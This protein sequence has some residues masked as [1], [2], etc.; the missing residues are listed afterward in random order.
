MKHT[1]KTFASPY[2][3]LG[4]VRSLAMLPGITPIIGPRFLHPHPEVRVLPSPGITRLLQYYDP[5]PVPV[6]P[7][8][9]PRAL[10]VVSTRAGVPPIAQ[11]TLPACRAHYPGGPEA[12]RVSVASRLGA[13]FPVS[14]AGRR[15][16]LHFRGL[17]R[18]HSRY[19][20]QGCSAT[21][22]GPA[23]ADH[24]TPARPVTGPSRLSATR[25]TD[26]YLGGTFTHR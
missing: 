4:N 19:R 21:V 25:L 10:K 11:T 12:G 16:R 22:R 5:L 18:L 26:H 17:L 3:A 8:S 13:A 15:P 24:K 2:S 9:L 14:Q 1:V 23:P 6:E 7:P 20:L